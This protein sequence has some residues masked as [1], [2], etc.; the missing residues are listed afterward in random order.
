MAV[1]RTSIVVVTM[2]LVAAATGRLQT[3]SPLGIVQIDKTPPSGQAADRRTD[4][5]PRACA[6]RAAALW[7]AAS[8]R[9]SRSAIV[10][11]VLRTVKTWPGTV[12]IDGLH[13]DRGRDRIDACQ[14]HARTCGQQ[15]R[16]VRVQVIEVLSLGRHQMHAIQ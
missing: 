3:P 16:V 8:I 7:H 6:L 2:C 4:T 15:M 10:P 9:G 1:P 5:S 13:V 12:K 11:A 14:M